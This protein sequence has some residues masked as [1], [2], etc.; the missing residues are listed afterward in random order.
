M[1]VLRLIM[2]V[3]CWAH[4]TTTLHIIVASIWY[5]WR[6]THVIVRAKILKVHTVCME[7][8]FDLFQQLFQR[9]RFDVRVWI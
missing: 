2:Y 3:M 1:H 9:V 7:G 8:C 5:S 6:W 4:V